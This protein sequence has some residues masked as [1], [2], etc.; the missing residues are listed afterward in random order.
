MGSVRHTAP[1]ALLAA[2][3]LSSVAACDNL[4]LSG[5][6]NEISVDIQASG[7]EQLHL[8][9]ST[10]W[11]FIEDPACNSDEQQC[12]EVLR[13]LDAD[14]STVSATYQRR[15]QFTDT[16]KYFVEVYPVG[17]VTATLSMK[18]EI[19]GREWYNESRELTP[20]GDN[21]RQQ[22]LQFVYQWQEPTIR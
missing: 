7:A 18:V 9:T 8:V 15:L 3:L 13:L 6:P 2:L 11:L 12:Q 10:N 22:T 4:G 21:G 14:T 19:D 16:H 5:A 17:G 20:D 1:T